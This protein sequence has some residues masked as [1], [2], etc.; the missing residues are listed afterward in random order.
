MSTL[1]IAVHGKG[2]SADTST[3]VN[4]I[5]E[6]FIEYDVVTPSYDSD[7][8]HDEVKRY[9]DTYVK[10]YKEYDTVMVIGISLGGYWAR[11]LANEIRGAKY[12][13]LNPSFNFYG[14]DSGHVDRSMLPITLYVTRDDEVVDPNYAIKK[15]MS[16]G[17]L[18]ILPK[19]GHRLLNVLDKVLDEVALDIN[20]I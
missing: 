16:R 19:G 11:Y 15:Y 6:R 12:V 2:G 1:I 3:T 17:K 7:K 13:G 18:H 9:I 8:S 4:K 5:K 20:T 10:E 14:D